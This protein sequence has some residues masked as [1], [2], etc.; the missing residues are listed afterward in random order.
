MD[1]NRR[2]LP[3]HD[4]TKT[5]PRGKRM[6]GSMATATKRLRQR[7]F[8]ERLEAFSGLIFWAFSAILELTWV[9]R[10]QFPFFH[11]TV[12]S[13][14]AVQYQPEEISTVRL[15]PLHCSTIS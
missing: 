13:G 7:Y 12:G 3:D 1:A 14:Q 2:N 10:L 4:D 6:A 9:A 11:L 8:R 5:P 15:H